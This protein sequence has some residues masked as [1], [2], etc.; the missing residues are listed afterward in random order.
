M[1]GVKQEMMKT[2]RSLAHRPKEIKKEG[3]SEYFLYTIEGKETIPNGWSKRL[4]SFSVEKVPVV[5]LYKYDEE[6]FGKKAVRV[7][8]FRNDRTHDLG[9]T[10]IPG[11]ML[12]LFREK[13]VGGQLTYEGQSRFKYIPMDEDIELNLGVAENVIIRP[14]LMDY[15]TDHY[16]FDQDG[17]ISGWDEVRVF[18]VTMKN[19]RE[20]PVKVEVRRHFQGASWEIEKSGDFGEFEKVDLDTVRFTLTLQARET[21]R[22]HYTLRSRHGQRAD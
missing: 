1:D 13:G 14:V 5:N 17:R 21:K 8:S 6:R 9:R 10:P 3:L 12:K 7:L 16:L 19:T 22:F 20:I 4:P 15:K 11:G 2:A 18:E